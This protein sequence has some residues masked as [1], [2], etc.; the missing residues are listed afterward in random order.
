M[1]LTF[2]VIVDFPLHFDVGEVLLTF[3]QLLIQVFIDILILKRLILALFPSRVLFAVV[4][5]KVLYFWS[6]GMVE[7]HNNDTQ[8]T[9][10]VYD[11]SHLLLPLH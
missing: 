3:P 7:H 6:E 1:V 2:C 9:K 4:V 8:Y 5:E 10:S 11:S